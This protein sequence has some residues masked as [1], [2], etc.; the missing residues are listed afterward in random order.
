MKNPAP[1][2]VAGTVLLLSRPHCDKD[3]P[4]GTC[5][6]AGLPPAQTVGAV[7]LAGG[8]ALFAVGIPLWIVGSR[9][10]SRPEAA[11]TA[12]RVAIG[13]GSVHLALSF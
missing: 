13:P 6:R 12:P 10:S 4:A 3:S 5:V 1:A 9:P 11:A 7:L 8:G 2:T